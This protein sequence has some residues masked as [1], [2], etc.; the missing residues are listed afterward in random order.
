MRRFMKWLPPLFS[1]SAL[2][3]DVILSTTACSEF[4][5][6]FDQCDPHTLEA[7]TGLV[8]S[9]SGGYGQSAVTYSQLTNSGV[10]LGVRASGTVAS[11]LYDAAG[12]SAGYV[13]IEDT[14]RVLSGQ[15]G[16]W[17]RGRGSCWARSTV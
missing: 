12:D 15:S 1:V 16:S 6:I 14:Y 10:H 7:L 17:I 4:N 13:Q 8:Q 3:G 2:W 9:T 5:N 11:D